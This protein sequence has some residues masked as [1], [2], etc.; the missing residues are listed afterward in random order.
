[1]SHAPFVHLRAHSA[2]SLSEGAIRLDALVRLCRELDMPAVA[3]T[4]T[5]NL[6][7]AIEFSHVASDAGV[8]PIVGCQLALVREETGGARSGFGQ[9]GQSGP[10]SDPVVVLVQSDAG[11]R[12]LLKLIRI[13]HFGAPGAEAPLEPQVRLGDFARH[14][15]GLILLTG[16]PAGPV[17]RLLAAGQGPAAD[18]VLV[19]LAEAFPG[20]LYVELM[21]HGLAVEKSTEPGFLDLA[22]RHGLPLVATNEAF[23][24]ERG[25][26]EAHDALLCIAAGATVSAA[27]RR[28]AT[29]EHYLK[30]PD[31]MRKLFADLPE[32]VDNTLVIARRCAFMVER[33][34]PI[35]PPY[36]CGDGV[37]EIDELKAQAKAGLEGR[38]ISCVWKSGMGKDE[39]EAV[40]RSYRERL[41]YEIAVIAKMGYPGYFLIVADFIRWAKAQGIP[42]GPGRG[43]GAGSVVAWALTITDLD[44][45]RFG[46]LFERFLNPERVSMPDFDIDFCQDRRDEVIHYVQDRYGRD[47]VAQIITFG[48]LQ[49]RAVLR[50]VGRVLEMPYGQVDKLCKLV[51]NNPAKP[52][53]LDEAI[54][55]EPLL[56]R[57]IEEDRAVERLIAIAR[58]LEGLYRHAS[59][60]AGGVVI[61]DRPLDELI[62]LYRDPK[63]DR[64]VTGFNMKYV[65]EAGLIKFDFLG[66]KTLT[67][68]ADAAKLVEKGNGN[69]LDLVNLPLDDEATF[70]M[71]ARGDTTGVF[72]LESAGMRDVLRNL[73]ADCFEDIIAVVALYRPGPMGNIPSYIRRKHGQEKPDY[74]YPTLEGILKETFGIII[75]QEQV[76][77]IAQ[78]LAGFSL[79]HADLIRR[80]M[81]KKI[82][83]EM[84]KQRETFVAGA[85]NRNVPES[86]ARDIF[87][88]V[89][90][91]A[92]YG[93]NKSHA[94]TYAMVAY[95]T[96]YMK[97]HH[98][99]EFMAASMTHDMANT[100][101][102]NVFRQELDRMGIRL[103][104]PDVNAS[105]ARFSV[106]RDLGGGPAIR[107]ALA[108]VRNVGAAAME[109]LVTE[110]RTNGPF[111]DLGDF[112]RRL[113][114]KLAN[115]RQI[116]NLARAGAFD[117]LNSNRRQAFEG[118]EEILKHAHA[119]AEERGSSQISLFGGG[120]GGGEAKLNLPAASDWSPMDRLN[121]EF[122]AIGFYLSSHPLDAYRRTLARHGVRTI[123][124][125]SANPEPGPVRLA[126]TVIGKKERTS[127][128]GNRYAFVQFS[129][130]T[131]VF[132]AIVFSDTL[133]TTRSL[134]EVGR[135]LLVRAAV[136]VEGETFRLTAQGLE[137]LEE[138]A[139][140][141]AAGV[142]IVVASQE[143][144]SP[145][146]DIIADRKGSSQEGKKGQIKLVSRLDT[147]HEVEFDLG[148][149]R[150][151]PAA[152]LAL[153]NV[154]G[155]LE[156]SE[157]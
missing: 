102:L 32:A 42:V 97:A 79:G 91:F 74:L 10:T 142:R 7:G 103:L 122:E 82:K 128:K 33:V 130:M 137:S 22:Y 109:S 119:A 71:L 121:H 83:S 132:E 78:E 63:S 9:G 154:S 144:L 88:L 23:F 13:A 38:L 45:L 54:A 98:P 147:G 134:L 17:G 157:I 2:Y 145:I 84:N 39:K 104:P 135:S 30:S 4:D 140:R 85:R 44:P 153:R 60:H 148:D 64:L 36:A 35:L 1:M 111:R 67:V 105:E 20:R 113:A 90:K 108:A 129:D 123:A 101:K 151:T 28:R 14:A 131:G 73:K 50:D 41:D 136:Q 81:G 68:L 66:L 27:E 156:A 47:R 106:G 34:D 21:R 37:S 24:T 5:N 143:S 100:D 141:T 15:E 92:D 26:H 80:A 125:V 31:E 87:D 40:A 95:Q 53:T 69:H 133:A 52:V 150:L 75:Y 96:A 65:E 149:R 127:A 93:F 43:S 59:T 115:K 126:G 112:A 12:N 62:P 86:R 51:P 29:P 116:E 56:Q 61:G 118:V 139:A 76:M 16:G 57:A 99:V 138:V 77:Q 8:Q 155:V 146:R 117:S 120:A 58:Q 11:Y 25:M 72:Q 89:A 152:L 46:L 55:E 94:A 49:A 124:E 19:R 114:A 18:T 48:K 70:S 110:R 3:V 107:Y 6:F